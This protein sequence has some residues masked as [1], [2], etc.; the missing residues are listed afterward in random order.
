MRLEGKVAVVTGGARG[1]G[2]AIVERYVGEGAAVAIADRVIDPAE[3][4][5]KDL[6]ARAFVVP[7]DVTDQASIEAMVA[8]V[9]RR[10]GGIDILVNNAAV[11]DLAPIVEVTEK[12]WD[13]LFSVNVKGLF[14][15]LQAVAR[16][17]IVQGRGGKI[18]NMASQAGR[19]GEALVSIYC[20]TKAALHSFALSLRHQLKPLKIEVIE[21]CPP[22]V[23]TDLGAPGRNKAG[24][25]VDE[26]A[27]GVMAQF[28]KGTPEITYGTATK[29][30]HASRAER[31][32]LFKMLNQ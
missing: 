4:L 27:D 11:F 18:I 6:G 29:W 7:L 2:A 32:E 19:R 5:A 25:P 24:I 17:M 22:H 15:T 14:F 8:T 1:I 28:E 21:V 23:D 10:T 20:A 16:R 26:F 30:A 12:S 13:L 31:D 3:Q 9:V